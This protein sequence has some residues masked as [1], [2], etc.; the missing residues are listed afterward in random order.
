[1]SFPTRSGHHVGRIRRRPRSG[2][3]ILAESA[4]RDR[5]DR[6]WGEFGLVVLVSALLV[7]A[8]LA[9]AD[10]HPLPLPAPPKPIKPQTVAS[11]DAMSV[12]DPAA[13]LPC[14]AV[15]V[16]PGHPPI[17]AQIRVGPGWVEIDTTPCQ[18]TIR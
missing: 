1:M 6:R 10:G 12:L 18:E 7:A 17:Y 16:P 13:P 15:P 3:D 4:A 5:R 11:I 9:P 8:M 14:R 2:A